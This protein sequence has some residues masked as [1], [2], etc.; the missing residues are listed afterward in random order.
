MTDEFASLPSLLQDRYLFHGEVGR[1]G[2]AVV[3]LATDLKHQREVAI[4]V[5]HPE[6]TTT[7]GPAR[8]HRE[9]HLAARL[10][11]PNIV[12]LYDSGEAGGFL[13]Y[14]MPYVPGESL[15]RRLHREGMLP[16]DLAVRI[17]VEVAEALEYAHSLGVVHR[18][19][20]PDNILLSGDHP[21]VAD[22]GL[23]SALTDDT[24]AAPLTRSGIVVGT[25]LYMS[26]EQA[27]GL[28]VGPTSDIYSLG[29]VLFEM[30]AGHPPFTGTTPRQIL[31][32]HAKEQVPSLKLVRDTVPDHV[33]H[34]VS[35]ALN[36]AVV[37]RPATARQFAELLTSPPPTSTTAPIAPAEAPAATG[38]DRKRGRWLAG[39]LVAIAIAVAVGLLRMRGSATATSDDGT[40]VIAVLPFDYEGQPG[41]AYLADGVADEVRGKLAR[42]GGLTVIARAS[43]IEYRHT[44]KKPEEIARDLGVQY[45]LSG[46]LQWQKADSG[47][48]R[49]R[50]RPELVEV[51][52][53]GA[54]RT[55]W[56]EQFDVPF[57]GVFA[58]QT[59]IAE[60]VAARLD[61]V[62]T[63]SVSRQLGVPPTTN[64]LA[65]DA[66]LRG[67]QLDEE[68]YAADAATVRR[69]IRYL[70]QAVALD[71]NFALAWAR[72][73]GTRIWLYGN[74]IPTRETM[75]QAREAAERALR[76]DP[77]SAASRLAMGF[78]Y[79]IVEHDN[80]RARIE[81]QTALRL[82]PEDAVTLRRLATLEQSMGAMDSAV[83]HA[84]RASRLDPR[85]IGSAVRFAWIL[86]V[87]RRTPEARLVMNRTVAQAPASLV[88]VEERALD[89]LA[90]GNLAGAQSVIG[91]VPAETE[92]AVLVAYLANYQDLFWVL[93]DE[94]RRLL[95]TLT[96]AEFD[97][98]RG[99]WALVRAET[100]WMEGDST[101]MRS[102]ADTARTEF[103]RQLVS[104]PVD[105]QRLVLM[106]L[107][108]AYLGRGEEGIA[109][110][111]RGVALMPIE[112]D[113]INGTYFRHLLARVYVVA[114]KSEQ[115]I[116]ILEQLL[117]LPYDLTPAWLR[118]DP[119]FAPLKGNPRFVRLV[120]GR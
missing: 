111:E 51:Q 101:R 118:I 24:G 86:R 40:P 13:Y 98:D 27:D 99:V 58:V 30:L 50:V 88:A 59:D 2:A 20:K 39:G 89:E 81:Y 10:Q 26:P 104:A 60:R 71:S 45:L 38:V 96:P 52:H 11:H 63:D 35:V 114:G 41:D 115:A 53:G 17:A 62:L 15:G 117:Q 29:C 33:E 34:A 32:R 93:T 78:Y 69:A 4:K 16:V 108:L 61:L 100:W 87:L 1:G 77:G 46:T 72:L 70:E 56:T 119:N 5:L 92:P 80:A 82:D 28:T 21:L 67:L 37:D 112:R 79:A 107:A 25:P 65:Y 66:Y 57:T 55:R 68:Q 14:V 42:I 22:F 31:A 18:D 8:F 43:S 91:A 36:K 85:S 97:G 7:V 9:I 84:E 54:P 47:A 102:A 120:G 19:I 103:A 74:T 44:G 95:L 90:D 49:V 23:A 110:A 116:D 113:H 48:G 73:A 6:V 12:P 109:T 75:V 76:L 64:L 3:F 106:G 94:Q 105:P 83:V